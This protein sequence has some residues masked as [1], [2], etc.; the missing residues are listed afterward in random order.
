MVALRDP[1]EEAVRTW[2]AVCGAAGLPQ[3]TRLTDERKRRLRAALAMGKQNPAAW[4]ATCERIAASSIPRWSMSV[5]IDWALK[6][7][8][9]L[10]IL[11]GN[12]D[13]HKP[14]APDPDKLVNGFYPD[15]STVM[16]RKAWGGLRPV[17]GS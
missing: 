8:N 12:Y 9:L 2:N 6:P 17:A 10:K 1:I 3:A 11:E 7:A 4:R 15:G 5:G 13:D 14:A 16:S